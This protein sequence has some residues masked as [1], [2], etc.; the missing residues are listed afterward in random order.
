M[1][2]SFVLR[3]LLNVYISL[4]LITL[5]KKG[6]VNVAETFRKS[7]VDKLIQ[8]LELRKQF[9]EEYHEKELNCVH[10]E[11][12]HLP[13]SI[14]YYEGQIRMIN[15]VIKDIHDIFGLSEAR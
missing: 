11:L 8:R 15:S 1:P 6:V 13:N 10:P 12:P 4:L 9:T 3:M 2:I 7:K 5:I 14:Q